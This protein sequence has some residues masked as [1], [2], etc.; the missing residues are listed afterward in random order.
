MVYIN[1][2][3]VS[4]IIQLACKQSWTIYLLYTLNKTAFHCANWF[5]KSLFCKVHNYTYIYTGYLCMYVRRQDTLSYLFIYVLRINLCAVR[6]FIPGSEIVSD[7]SF[8]GANKYLIKTSQKTV[9]KE[10]NVVLIRHMHCIF[11][12]WH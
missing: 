9:E 4:G 7:T 12:R 3:N 5:W 8:V 6:R 11:W 10:W 1:A 2:S